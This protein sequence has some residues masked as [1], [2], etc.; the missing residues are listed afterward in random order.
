MCEVT[1]P[2]TNMWNQNPNPMQEALL[3]LLPVEKASAMFW[4]VEG[5]KWRD[6][7][8]RIKYNNRWRIAYEMGRWYGSMLK[9][10]GLYDDIDAV[11]PVPLHPLRQ[12]KRGYNQS[13]YIAEGMAREMGVEFINSAVVRRRYNRSQTTRS[14]S[15]RWSNVEGIFSVRRKKRL[16]GK[17]IL[18]VDDVFTT[19][20]TIISL[21]STILK[22]VE[23]VRLSVAVLAASRHSL[24][25][26][27]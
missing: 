13:A 21:G 18:L 24:H 5:S 17:H 22:S 12:M 6:M 7:I 2:L 26:E 3:G 15:Q 27:P 8:H 20:A 25:I 14:Q 10:S 11:V 9:Q 19:G 23:D 16:S 4:Y 1:A